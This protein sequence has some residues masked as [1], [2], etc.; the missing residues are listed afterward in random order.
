MGWLAPLVN[1]CTVVILNLTKS[2]P[3]L[4]FPNSCDSDLPVQK[5]SMPQDSVQKVEV[6]IASEFGDR[7]RSEQ[8]KASIHT[9]AKA[10]VGNVFVTR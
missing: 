9:S 3:Q 10:H 8:E 5:L 2:T 1:V 7:Q 6:K 4:L